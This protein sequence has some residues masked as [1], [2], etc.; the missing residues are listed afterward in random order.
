LT[1]NNAGGTGY[2]I[3]RFDI[4]KVDGEMPCDWDEEEPDY[5]YGTTGKTCDYSGATIKATALF[6]P[7]ESN[8][9]EEDV[10]CWVCECGTVAPEEWS[11]TIS[12]VTANHPSNEAFCAQFNDTHV[13]SKDANCRWS[14][15]L[16]GATLYLSLYEQF[17]GPLGVA[18][19][20]NVYIEDP[21]SMPPFGFCG[22]WEEGEVDCE[23][24]TALTNMGSSCAACDWS[25][26]SISI[27]AL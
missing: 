14:I 17:G 1:V 7:C 5:L 13:L 24:V 25:G 19:S 2:G 15:E 27:T 20:V 9:P 8:P 26:A 12:G 18:V 6:T 11:V 22:G 3:A 23:G 16:D 10:G 4:D 21:G